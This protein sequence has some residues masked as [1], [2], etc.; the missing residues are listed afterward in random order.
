MERVGREFERL[1]ESICSV[2]DF[3]WNENRAAMAL[4]WG[5]GGQTG[6]RSERSPQA[7]AGIRS[8]SGPTTSKKP[9][10]MIG[11]KRSGAL[12]SEYEKYRRKGVAF[13]S[14]INWVHQG[15]VKSHICK[16]SIQ[17]SLFDFSCEIVH[18]Y[19]VKLLYPQRNRYHFCFCREEDTT[20]YVL[21]LSF[22]WQPQC[23]AAHRGNNLHLTTCT[24]AKEK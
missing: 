14:K 18:C 22:T 10:S 9:Y 2:L 3:R 21:T 1:C 15:E 7:G 24:E 23:S 19:N 11:A 20:K 16:P 8:L 12:F 17:C 6:L 13:H 4:T 5:H